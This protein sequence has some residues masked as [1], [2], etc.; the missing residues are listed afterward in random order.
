MHKVSFSDGVAVMSSDAAETLL[1]SRCSVSN[2]RTL[3][4]DIKGADGFVMWLMLNL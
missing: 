3:A 2:D 1:L 4:R